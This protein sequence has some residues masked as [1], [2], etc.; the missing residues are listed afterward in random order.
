MKTNIIDSC[1]CPVGSSVSAQNSQI[2][3]DPTISMP[4]DYGSC[5]FNTGDYVYA[6]QTGTQF[7]TKAQITTISNGSYDILFVDSGFT[8]TTSNIN[9]LKVYFPTYFNFNIGDEVNVIENGNIYYRHATII[10]I[11]DV[12]DYTVVFDNGI[13]QTVT[14]KTTLRKL[15][16]KRFMTIYGGVTIGYGLFANSG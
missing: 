15:V 4:V 9:D 8:L 5:D 1:V 7:Y 3:V 11:S 2:Y 12:G 16:Q 6:V 14:D 10:D 13:E